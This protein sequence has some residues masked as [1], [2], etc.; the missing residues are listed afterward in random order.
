NIIN[1]HFCQG[2]LSFSS[3]RPTACCLTLR[4]TTYPQP[5]V[6]AGQRTQLD[7]SALCSELTVELKDR[8]RRAG[9]TPSGSVWVLMQLYNDLES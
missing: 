8:D 6:L 9:R 4:L 3:I 2:S 1:N 7:T 5:F